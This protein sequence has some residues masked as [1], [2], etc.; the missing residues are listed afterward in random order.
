MNLGLMLVDG[1][2]SLQKQSVHLAAI[3]FS[4]VAPDQR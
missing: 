2:V 1:F 3:A 4:R